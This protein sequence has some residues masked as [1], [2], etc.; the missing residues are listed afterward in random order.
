MRVWNRLASGVLAVAAL[1]ALAL[2]QQQQGSWGVDVIGGMQGYDSSSGL[3][4]GAFVG[5]AAL[6]Q[7]TNHIAIGPSLQYTRNSSDETFFTGVLD[8]G[9][10]S[11][12]V[13]QVGQT[14]NSLHYS[15]D[16]RFDFLPAQDLDP[17]VTGG[18]GGYTMYLET[19][20][21]DGHERA[22]DLM[23]QA[24]GGIRWNISNGAG[25]ELDVRDVIYTGYNR[26][27]LNPIRPVHW[28]CTEPGNPSSGCRFPD[29]ETQTPDKKDTIHNL[30]FAIGLTFIPGSN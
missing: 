8:F 30:R 10:D 2:G 26:D 6:Y 21:I 7:V 25:I 22:S 27:V 28:N 15:L 12:R 5:V 20:A 3:N 16:G 4:S 9:A 23:F 18:V 11:A 29:A 14:I 19:Q 24:G 13:Y 1:P 17:Y